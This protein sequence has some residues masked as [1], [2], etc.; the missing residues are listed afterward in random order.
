[1]ADPERTLEV[2]VGLRAIGV[3]TALDDFGAGHVVARPPQAAR[4]RRAQDRPLVRHAARRRRARRRDR[5]L[6]G[7]PRPPARDARRRRGRRDAGDVGHARRLQCDEAQGFYLGRPMTATALA[8]W[9]RD[10]AAAP[11]AAYARYDRRAGWTECAGIWALGGSNRGGDR[12][13][14]AGGS[15][16]GHRRAAGLRG[17]AGDAPARRRRDPGRRGGARA[18]AG[19]SGCRW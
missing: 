6:D 17:R 3:A 12:R 14:R 10:R 2:L 7:R 5:A 19:R 8:G 4:R 15:V 11:P 13:A 1:M 9:L 18:L 16:A